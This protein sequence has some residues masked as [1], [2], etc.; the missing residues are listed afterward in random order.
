MKTSNGFTVRRINNNFADKWP[1]P[2][3]SFEKSDS[4]GQANWRSL[5]SYIGAPAANEV[6]AHYGDSDWQKFASIKRFV[7]IS[8]I[9][10]DLDS[11]ENLFW[12]CDDGWTF[13]SGATVFEGEGALKIRMPLGGELRELPAI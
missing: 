6:F 2:W 13:L 1:G 7:V 3:Y 5:S 12:N 8:V 9:D 10:K 11:G 4:R